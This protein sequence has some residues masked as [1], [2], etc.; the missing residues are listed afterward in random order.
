MLNDFIVLQVVEDQMKPSDSAPFISGNVFSS[1]TGLHFKQE[2][3]SG[4]LVIARRKISLADYPHYLIA[5]L[6][7]WKF[8]QLFLGVK[9][10]L[11][12]SVFLQVE[13]T[14]LVVANIGYRI[15]S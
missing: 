1:F 12:V 7:L 10:H 4:F 9:L 3:N 5:F 14:E 6:A 2:Q 15:D 11:N 13:K 8:L